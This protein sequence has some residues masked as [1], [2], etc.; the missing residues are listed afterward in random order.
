MVSLEATKTLFRLSAKSPSNIGE[1]ARFWSAGEIT[2]L[3]ERILDQRI[4]KLPAS[5]SPDEL[6]LLPRTRNSLKNAGLLDSLKCLEGLTIRE[7]LE[8][9]NF[10]AHSLEDLMRALG[11]LVPGGGTARKPSRSAHKAL[12]KKARK[13]R[14]TKHAE[15]VC[16]GDPRFHSSLQEIDYRARDARHA[17][18]RLISRAHK[19]GDPAA[20]AKLIHQLRTR[21]NSLSKLKLEDELWD[22][23]SLARNERDRRI[24]MRRFGWDGKDPS[25]LRS[26]GDLF[27]VAHEYVRVIGNPIVQSLNGKRAFAPALDR[28]LEFISSRAGQPGAVV[29]NELLSAGLLGSQFSLKSLLSAAEI[30]G[31]DTALLK[32]LLGE[33]ARSRSE[34]ERIQGLVRSATRH[35]LRGWGMTVVAEVLSQLRRTEKEID[36]DALVHVLTEIPG[37]RWLDEATGW[38]CVGAENTPAA[39]RVKKALGVARRL[40]ISDLCAVVGRHRHRSQSL[41]IPSHVML[42]FCRQLPWCRIRG[43]NVI[44]D[45]ELRWNDVLPESERVIVQVLKE[46]GPIL[47]WARLR[48]LCVARGMKSKTVEAFVSYSLVTVKLGFGAW[49]LLG[50]DVSAKELQRVQKESSPRSKISVPS[51]TT[52]EKLRLKSGLNSTNSSAAAARRCRIILASA[53]GETPSE[54]AASTGCSSDRVR[55]LIRNFKKDRLAFLDRRR[56]G[57]PRRARPGRKAPRKGDLAAARRIFDSATTAELQ[58]LVAQN[59]GDFGKTQSRWTGPLLVQVCLELGLIPRAV[60]PAAVYK[61]LRAVGIH[62]SKQKDEARFP[63]IILNGRVKRRVEIE[64]QSPD[65][66]IRVRALILLARARGESQRHIA[67]SLACSAGTVRRVVRKFAPGGLD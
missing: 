35:S 3:P 1:A 40:P 24:A 20:L 45:S 66:F 7:L 61:A 11:P 55:R 54:I 62:L 63:L 59:P 4:P 53:D 41:S 25:S 12:I 33:D 29:E 30:L 47:S 57:R 56:R 6:R 28:V 2:R 58:K 22:L 32:S 31:R 38:F 23:T 9:R 43:Y 13:L 16:K 48:E 14:N 67:R 65:R 8:I 42:N 19:P 15:L 5:I 37:F 46:H 39:I 49:G 51:L 50:A 10:G 44:G 52:E 27:G 21:I 60:T 36:S 64:S 26:V 17:A 34:S 18:E